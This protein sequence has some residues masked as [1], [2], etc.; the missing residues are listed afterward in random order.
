MLILPLLALQASAQFPV[1]GIPT[2]PAG[3]PQPQPVAQAPG[4]GY[5]VAQPVAPVAPPVPLAP[6]APT[7]TIPITGQ[8]PSSVSAA[9]PVQPV[10]SRTPTSPISNPVQGNPASVPSAVPEPIADTEQETAVEA[11]GCVYTVSNGASYNLNPI[12][13]AA[14]AY[15]NGQTLFGGQAIPFAM[16]G[17]CQAVAEC[18][19]G[20]PGQT[21][22]CATV[23]GSAGDQF[24]SVAEGTAGDL[25]L[26]DPNNFTAGIRL[27]WAASGQGF[28]PL[29]TNT[30]SQ[31]APWCATLSSEKLCV[32]NSFVQSG[33]PNKCGT[34]QGTQSSA[35]DEGSFKPAQVNLVMLCSPGVADQ[36]QNIN[37]TMNLLLADWNACT[38]D[39]AI[40]SQSACPVGLASADSILA[41]GGMSGFGVFVLFVLSVAICYIGV[42][43]AYNI[44]YENLTGLDAFPHIHFWATVPARAK[45]GLAN[46]GESCRGVANHVKASTSGS[47]DTVTYDL[48]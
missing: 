41:V 4:A 15:W 48:V 14:G 40:V 16:S 19:T 11:A 6:Q 43:C 35:F 39:F 30:G 26:V 33:C 12:N 29:T 20:T 1:A 10:A 44:K 47:G 8:T 5:P 17:P 22:L 23:P 28:C 36:P 2:A 45:E 38:F 24:A 37:S 34:A 32:T 27:S 25:S 18:G 9:Q 13:K 7:A 46:V 42:G 3:Y 21:A 31:D